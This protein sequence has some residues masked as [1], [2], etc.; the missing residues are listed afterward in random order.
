[1]KHSA[2]DLAGTIG[3]DVLREFWPRAKR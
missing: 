1:L 2:V 3:V